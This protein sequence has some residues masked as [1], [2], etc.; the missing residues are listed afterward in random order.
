MDVFIAARRTKQGWRY[1]F[2]RFGGV[3]NPKGL[4]RN[5]YNIRIGN[6]K[7][8]VNLPKY[9]MKPRQ[10]SAPTKN[11][12]VVERNKIN[13]MLRGNT[14]YADVI[15]YVA[16]GGNMKWH[17]NPPYN[18]GKMAWKG[19]ELKVDDTNTKWLSKCLIGRLHDPLAC[20][21]KTKM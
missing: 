17:E 12:R 6:V 21:Q 10:G 1:G 20:I 2:L 3:T 13:G 9:G 11:A 18:V 5:L 19:M 7:L 8:H 4:E 16:T 15:K 14:T